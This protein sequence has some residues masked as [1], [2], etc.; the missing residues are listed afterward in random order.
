[1]EGVTGAM[2][3]RKDFVKGC[4]AAICG[5][6]IS[7]TG[8]SSAAQVAE[9]HS[10]DCDLKQLTQVRDRADAARLRFSRLIE[11]IEDR[12]PEDR[13][14]AILRALGGRCADTYRAALL[15]RY[16][17]DIEGFLAEGRRNWMAEAT[18]DKEKGTIRIVDKGPSCSCPMV[19]VGNTPPSFCDCTLGWQEEAYSEILGKRVKAELEES[20]LRGG[21]KCVYRITII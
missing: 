5:S 8:K 13:R 2:I 20:I 7:C 17:G 19:K 4:A 16:K 1:M 15:D 6:G 9:E 10:G 11:I 18:Y 3:N 14:K 21:K 12:L